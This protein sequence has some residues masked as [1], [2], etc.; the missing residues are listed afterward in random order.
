VNRVT[1]DGTENSDAGIDEAGRPQGM[2]PLVDDQ[3]EHYVEVE[4]S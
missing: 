1:L 2:I 3:L 4:L